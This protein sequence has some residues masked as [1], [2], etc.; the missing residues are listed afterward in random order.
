LDKQCNSFLDN[1]DGLTQF[2]ENL[3]RP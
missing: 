2:C 3:V 1:F